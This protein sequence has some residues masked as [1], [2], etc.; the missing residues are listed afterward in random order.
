MVS[1]T[2]TAAF[3]I[4]AAATTTT[5]APCIAAISAP[6]ATSTTAANATADSTAV[7]FNNVAVSGVASSTLADLIQL[8]QLRH[9]AAALSKSEKVAQ[10]FKQGDAKAVDLDYFK[11]LLAARSEMHTAM[12]NKLHALRSL[13]KRNN[14][15][16]K[17]RK[18]RMARAAAAAAANTG[19]NNAAAVA[20][21]RKG[22]VTDDK[23]F[24]TR[25]GM[26]DLTSVTVGEGSSVVGC[27]S[28][29]GVV[30]GWHPGGGIPI[31]SS[32]VSMDDHEA[33]GA[34]ACGGKPPNG[35]TMHYRMMMNKGLPYSS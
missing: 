31:C 34:A 3:D 9:D 33:G 22:H 17:F 25:S 1:T 18:S 21:A 2:S 11:A 30:D 26:T 12:R 7:V 14:K 6:I 27:R 28:V 8:G 20:D 19:D 35:Q 13:R 4:L 24:S 29:E 23:S 15:L 16:D 5:V 10:A 32:P